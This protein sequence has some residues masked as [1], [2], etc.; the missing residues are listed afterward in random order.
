MSTRRAGT[1][2]LKEAQSGILW[3]LV[4]TLLFNLLN[5]S[6]KALALHYPVMELVWARLVVNVVVLALMFHRRLPAVLATPR[7]GAQLGRSLIL[8]VITVLIFTSLHLMP[9]ADY[10]AIMFLAP[11]FTTA[12]SMPLLGERVGRRRWAAVVVGFLGALV[13]VRPGLGVADAAALVPMAAAALLALYYIST[14]WLSRTDSATTTLFYTPLVGAVAA[15]VAVPFVWVSP[16]AL[17]ALA[18]VGIGIVGMAAHF[19]LIK[20]FT[21]APAATV[22]PFNYV[23]LIWATSLGFAVFGDLPDAGTLLGAAIIALS[24]LYILRLETGRGGDAR[25]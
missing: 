14:R 1:H 25:R 20:A 22:A 21:A 18:M 23:N 5:A 9:L 12:L 10:T 19:S 8:F 2:G 3:M 16:D 6:I 7:P 17:G 13:V 4:S 15:S 11:I 24:G